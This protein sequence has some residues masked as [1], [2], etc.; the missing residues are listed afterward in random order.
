MVQVWE[1]RGDGS[2]R[3]MVACNGTQPL[4]QGMCSG[5]R[6]SSWYGMVQVWGPWMWYG[7]GERRGVLERGTC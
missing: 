1:G 6:T 2:G 5:T 7:A 3:G 4:G